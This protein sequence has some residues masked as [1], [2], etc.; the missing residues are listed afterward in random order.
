[1]SKFKHAACAPI[2]SGPHWQQ[3]LRHQSRF[4]APREIARP[5]HLTLADKQGALRGLFSGRSR[6]QVQAP[7]RALPV[8]MVT[9][10]AQ[11]TAKGQRQGHIHLPDSRRLANYALQ[12]T[13]PSQD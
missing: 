10:D 12:L 9:Q 7:H 3:V 5:T 1:M 2:A 13:C 11:I 4:F 8:A 6:S